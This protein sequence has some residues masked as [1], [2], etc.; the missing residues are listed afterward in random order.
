M[1]KASATAQRQAGPQHGRSLRVCLANPHGLAL[2]NRRPLQK[3]Q[4][5]AP[6]QLQ[7]SPSP[8]LLPIN[9][10]SLAASSKRS[11]CTRSMN[12]VWPSHAHAPGS[13][14]VLEH[15]KEKLCTFRAIRVQ[16]MLLPVSSRPSP[17]TPTCGASGSPFPHYN[18]TGDVLLGKRELLTPPL[19]HPSLFVA[20]HRCNSTATAPGST[21]GEGGSWRDQPAP[22]AR[23]FCPMQGGQQTRDKA[24][25]KSHHKNLPT[26]G[27]R[28]G[29]SQEGQGKL[30]LCLAHGTPECHPGS[31]PTNRHYGGA[32][33]AL[34][35]I[36]TVVT[37]SS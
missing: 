33:T 13:G 17:G 25:S 29:V 14:E 1:E 23:I 26:S 5:A 32:A 30:G 19:E 16:P 9:S 12:R 18:R 22:V 37:K 7:L 35:N 10:F 11:S 34:N 31:P 28:V 24:N 27:N 21:P 8:A 15:H 36:Y 6:A 4:P 20:S 2:G 3:Y